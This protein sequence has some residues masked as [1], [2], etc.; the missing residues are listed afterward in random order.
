MYPILL[1]TIDNAFALTWK[2]AL[3]HVCTDTVRYLRTY[4]SCPMISLAIDISTDLLIHLILS[5]LLL[6]NPKRILG[7]ARDARLRAT[8]SRHYLLTVIEF[9]AG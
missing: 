2:T 7:T 8:S 5:V 4:V 9:R 3:L 1:W 6:S